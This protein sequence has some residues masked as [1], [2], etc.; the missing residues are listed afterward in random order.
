LSQ[1]GAVALVD[2][3]HGDCPYQTSEMKNG[4]LNQVAVFGRA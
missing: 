2:L 1:N 4:D 3:V